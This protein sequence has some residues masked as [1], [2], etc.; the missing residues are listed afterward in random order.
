MATTVFSDAFTEAGNIDLASHTPNVGGGWALG[1]D[2]SGGSGIIVLASV[3][4]ARSLN[5]IGNQRVIYLA[6]PSP[7]LTGADY[8]QSFTVT[9]LSTADRPMFVVARWADSSNFYAAG[10]RP[11]SSP[12]VVIAKM[13]SGTNTAIA[14]DDVGTISIGDV[15]KFEMRGTT[16]KLYQDAVEILSVTDSDLSAAGSFGIGFGNALG[17]ALDDIGSNNRLDDYLVVDETVAGGFDPADSHSWGQQSP[18]RVVRRGR[19]L[20]S[21]VTHIKGPRAEVEAQALLRRRSRVFL[22]AA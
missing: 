9:A 11:G 4:E 18:V 10:I 5:T 7:A 15:F 19:M 16:L 6:T 2:T 14:S 21:G 20:P 13:V 8:D 22:K 12:N 3:D 17:N 1:V